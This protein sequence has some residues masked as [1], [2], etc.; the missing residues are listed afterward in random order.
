MNRLDRESGKTWWLEEEM[1]LQENF[2]QPTDVL[3]THSG[4]TWTLPPRSDMVDHY[5]QAE[6]AIGKKTL[7]RELRDEAA[8]HDRLFELVHP[9]IWYHGHH[10]YSATHQVEG[11]TIRQLDLAELV[12]HSRPAEERSVSQR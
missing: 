5:A 10:H 12:L 11:C 4:P 6:A 7:R 3:V 1:V 2:A 9:R 8:R